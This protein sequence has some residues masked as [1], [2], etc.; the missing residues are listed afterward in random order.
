MR[1]YPEH[2]YNNILL[3]YHVR[4]L[5]G[6]KLQTPINRNI[7]TSPDKK[8]KNPMQYYVSYLR[9]HISGF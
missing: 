4:A 7:Y 3:P 8:R 6:S 1:R 2:Y 9:A 5:L